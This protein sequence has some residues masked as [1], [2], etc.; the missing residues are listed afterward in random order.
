MFDDD[1]DDERVL[2]CSKWNVVTRTG[3]GKIIDDYEHPYDDLMEMLYPNITKGVEEN[4]I[5]AWK[6]RKVDHSLIIILVVIAGVILFL[7]IV[8][9]YCYRRRMNRQNGTLVHSHSKISDMKI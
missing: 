8:V 2:I 1:D 7:I 4:F 5:N 6:S 9:C 3:E